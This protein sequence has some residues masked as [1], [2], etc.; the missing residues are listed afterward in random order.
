MFKDTLPAVM[1]IVSLL[2]TGTDSSR[3]YR[4]FHKSLG[5][6]IIRHVTV[7][8]RKDLITNELLALAAVCPAIIWQ[9]CAI[10]ALALM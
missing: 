5:M 2:S 10:L 4:L 1:K 6:M 9:F 3:P 8:G 7:C